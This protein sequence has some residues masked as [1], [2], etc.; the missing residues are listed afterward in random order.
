MLCTCF[1]LCAVTCNAPNK[2]SFLQFYHQ[3]FTIF[4]FLFMFPISLTN[5]NLW[6]SFFAGISHLHLM[7][8]LEPFAPS[9]A[10]TRGDDDVALFLGWQCLWLSRY[11]FRSNSYFFF[12]KLQLWTPANQKHFWK[13]LNYSDQWKIISNKEIPILVYPKKK[14]KQKEIEKERYASHFQRRNQLILL[15]YTNLQIKWKWGSRTF[16]ENRIWN[17]FWSPT[18]ILNSQAATLRFSWIEFS[19]AKSL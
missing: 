8:N 10:I 13:M 5:F 15:N 11:A 12:C 2:K 9:L 17:F 16:E 19:A 14:Y 6:F 18:L 1:P 7:L 4:F 3:L